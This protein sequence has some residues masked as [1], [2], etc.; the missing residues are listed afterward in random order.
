MNIWIDD[1]I[2]RLQ[3]QGGI[4]RLWRELT[5]CL[6]AALPDVT[7]DL[8]ASADVFMSTYYADAPDGVPSVVLYY[9][10]IHE[11]YPGLGKYHP[12]ALQK[13]RAVKQAAA[14]VAIS[15]AS[16]NDCL[17]YHG[18]GASVAYCGGSE[19]T[20][21][22]L[23][24]QV[25]AFRLKYGLARPYVLLVGRRDLYKNARALYEAWPLSQW[26][27]QGTVVAIGGE[28]PLPSDIEFANRYPWKQLRLPDDEL[29]LAYSGAHALVYPSYYEG[30]GLPIVEALACGCPVICGNL[31][32][33]PEVAGDAALY[34]DVC[35]PR[36][37]AT[38]L[39]MLLDPACRFELAMKGYERARMFT[40]SKM[41]NAIAKTIRTIA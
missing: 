26:A 14:V 9:D 3:G 2:Y 16:A 37:I 5:P 41:S 20:C 10:A 33:E 19:L 17:R 13:A 21:R 6:R 23:P 22:G 4:S 32:S 25:N 7:F 11:R 36:D 30:F 1:L 27:Q 39:D 31:S 28:E 38:A 18:V 12:D 8:S 15:Q 35:K 29:A 24:E 40:W 34:V